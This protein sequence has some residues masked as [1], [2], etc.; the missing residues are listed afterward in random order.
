MQKRNGEFSDRSKT[1]RSSAENIIDGGIREISVVQI[2]EMERDEVLCTGT[3]G[4][5]GGGWVGEN[6]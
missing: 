1:H 2:G 5:S 4:F 3:K 6:H